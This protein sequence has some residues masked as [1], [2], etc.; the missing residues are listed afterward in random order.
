M[1]RAMLVTVLRRMEDE[2]E[3]AAENAFANIRTIPG[4][5]MR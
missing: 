5:P 2:A 3:T 1:T 4:T